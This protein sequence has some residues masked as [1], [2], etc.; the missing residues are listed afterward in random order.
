MLSF[1]SIGP[2]WKS[3][4]GPLQNLK[5]C[6]CN[7]QG[8]DHCNQVNAVNAQVNALIESDENADSGDEDDDFFV[9]G[10]DIPCLDVVDV[11]CWR[12]RTPSGR[13]RTPR[14]MR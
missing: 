3:T 5:Q 1:I 10:S 8:N 14:L 9:L 12:L 2:G 13:P 7:D 6:P 11:G 4:S